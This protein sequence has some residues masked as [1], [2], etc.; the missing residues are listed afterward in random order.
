[1]EAIDLSQALAALQWAQKVAPP[2]PAK[3][4]QPF[5]SSAMLRQM[6]LSD[7]ERGVDPQLRYPPMAEEVTAAKAQAL[8]HAAADED[9]AEIDSL[10]SACD[11]DGTLAGVLLANL[12]ALHTPGTRPPWAVALATRRSS[13]LDALGRQSGAL[14]DMATDLVQHTHDSRALLGL[15]RLSS[16]RLGAAGFHRKNIFH[17]KNCCD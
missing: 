6:A 15:P 13:S 11:K 5:I 10:F 12:L 9:F 3:A 2:A 16:R 8:E 7:V 1:M 4:D 14:D 17:K